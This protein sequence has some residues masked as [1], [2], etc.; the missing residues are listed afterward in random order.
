MALSSDGNTA[1]VG[2]PS[3][4]ASYG[5]STVGAVWVFT[6]SGT[7]WTQQGPE[8]VGT[9]AVEGANQGGSVALSGDG[10]TALVGG[11]ED[12]VS[13]G[14]VWVFTRSGTTWTQQGPKLV[15]T[16]AVGDAVQGSSVALSRDGDTALV[17]APDDNSGKG[18][19][20]VFTRSRGRWTQ[21]GR[22]LVGTSDVGDANQGSSVAL[23]PDGNTALVGGIDDNRGRGAVWV[24]TRSRGRWTQQG[25]K[26]VGTGAVGDAEQGTSVALSPDGNIALVGA[27]DD[28]R[29]KGAVWVFT[30]SQGRW[31]QQGRKLVGTG[32]I[33]HAYQGTSVAL[34]DDG[35][36][37]LV[38][39]IGD[40][41]DVGAVWVFVTSRRRPTST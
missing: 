1:L 35:N 21:Q 19:V 29:G 14:A 12:N 4:D 5:A 2:G 11:A 33:G 3:Y 31:T 20:W 10:N 39:G 38:G 22:K 24:F 15:G 28:N 13:A 7:T 23:S 6:R 40:N 26:L 41:G 16:G 18:A 37:A 9:G 36:T 34:S 30:R 27:P 8:L 17:G 25:R 32:A